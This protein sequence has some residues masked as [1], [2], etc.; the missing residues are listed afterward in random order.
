MTDAPSLDPEDWEAFRGLA[1]RAV[2]DLIAHWRRTVDGEGPVW[3]PLPPEIRRRIE[4]QPLP[5]DG[6]GAEA[7][8]RAFLDLVLPFGTGNA[9]PRFWGWVMGA[10][11]PLGTL[12]DFLASGLNANAGGLEQAVTHV[13]LRVIRWLDEALGFSA[14]A[15][16]SGLLTSGASL[17]N[18]IALAVARNHRAGFDVR[19]E[20]LQRLD[21][22]EGAE[23]FGALL[24]VHGSRETHGSVPAA[25]ELLGLG[26]RAFREAP[27]RRD[28]SVSPKALA[29]A[30]AEDR[31]RGGRPVA[32]VANAGTVGTGAMDDLRA[33]ADLAAEHDLWLHVDGAFGALLALSPALRP[34]LAGLERADSL[35]FDLHK[36]ANLPYGVG[37]VL[38]RDGDAH[39]QAFRRSAPY[40]ESLPGGPAAR[41]APSFGDLGPELSRPARALKVWMALET[42]GVRGLAEV[43]ERSVEQTR[44]LAR[45]VDRHPRLELVAPRSPEGGLNIVCFRYRRR[46]LGQAVHNRLNRELLVGLQEDGVAVPSALTLH[47]RFCLRV[48]LVN[49]RTRRRDLDRLVAETARRGD[50]LSAR[51]AAGSERDTAPP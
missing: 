38:V 50:A 39:R 3:R 18:L 46:G 13:E 42:H 51:L 17:A 41:G 45:L 30:L 19:D 9:H 23:S 31:A 40:L 27:T 11:T 37:C 1:H 7:A 20:G 24:T 6:R 14:G 49:H 5:V 22:A 21:S 15:A 32:L 43:V 26:R 10:G 36:W 44:Y 28:G 12:A 2:D 33:L 16:G 48:A 29:K 8:Y 4:E 35:A 34:R 47:G 25:L